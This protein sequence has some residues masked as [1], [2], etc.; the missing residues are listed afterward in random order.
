[1]RCSSDL[2]E[3]LRADAR[4]AVSPG[5][6]ASDLACTTASGK[7]VLEAAGDGAACP[8]RGVVLQETIQAG[9]SAAAARAGVSECLFCDPNLL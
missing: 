3:Y 7:R 9:D 8:M 1:V 5:N 2:L 4:C 6:Q